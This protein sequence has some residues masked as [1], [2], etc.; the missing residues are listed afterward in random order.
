MAT[1]L[2]QES[3]SSKDEDEIRVGLVGGDGA[4]LVNNNV[5][6]PNP[7]DKTSNGDEEEMTEEEG[8][9]G[10]FQFGMASNMSASKYTMHTPRKGDE[11]LQ[12]GAGKESTPT[13]SIT[14]DDQTGS[15]TEGRE[16]PG[17]LASPPSFSEN[18]MKLDRASTEHQL[19]SMS[20]DS[21]EASSPARSSLKT[22]GS[23]NSLKYF[24][25]SLDEV[26]GIDNMNSTIRSRKRRS[27]VMDEFYN[28]PEAENLDAIETLFYSFK[29]W[30]MHS[31]LIFMEPILCGHD[32]RKAVVFVLQVIVLVL[33]S[34]SFIIQIIASVRRAIRASSKISGGSYEDRVANIIRSIFSFPDFPGA[35]IELICLACGWVF[36]GFHP[37]IAALRCFRLFRV[38]FYNDL[39]KPIRAKLLHG[40]AM[41]HN[42][43]CLGLPSFDHSLKTA[44]LCFQVVKFT[45]FSIQRLAFEMF[46]LTD[47]TRGGFILMVVLFYSGYLVGMSVFVDDGVQRDRDITWLLNWNS[48]KN[49]ANDDQLAAYEFSLCKTPGTCQSSIERLAVWD[50]NG[51]DYLWSLSSSR[52]FL[53]AIVT[54]YMCFTAFGV[55]NGL[56]GLFR[57]IFLRHSKLAFVRGFVV[58][59][60]EA[61]VRK[62]TM[63]AKERAVATLVKELAP[64]RQKLLSLKEKVEA[65]EIKHST[66]IS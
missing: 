59:D 16:S 10:R 3:S 17:P 50:G 36:L 12:R 2:P 65:L 22:W 4:D 63:L 13:G 35:V 61:K 6:L 33:S 21:I 7:L 64:L 66:F 57:F 31:A 34:A 45:A 37:G 26:D 56:T 47:K 18:P 1:I 8:S 39:P 42:V 55:L 52:G 53:F 43:A 19:A 27:S 28:S 32:P 46:V 40:L 54:V 24:T 9:K 15:A 58:I 38:L 41:L 29:Y 44:R 14:G 62:K 25:L 20:R 48:T 11:D 23:M 51:F 60:H 49:A 5:V 30:A